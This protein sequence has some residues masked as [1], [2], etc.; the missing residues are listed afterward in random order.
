MNVR[1]AAT[2]LSLLLCGCTALA[3]SR[4]LVDNR[5]ARELQPTTTAG[6]QIQ[7]AVAS[8]EAEAQPGGI[9]LNQLSDRGQAALIEQTK[10]KPPL[11]VKKEAEET[12][13]SVVLKNTITRRL[14]MTIRPSQFLQPGDRVDAIRVQ[15]KIA[16]ARAAASAPQWRIISWTQASAETPID[17]GKLTGV[18]STKITA[19]TGLNLPNLLPGLTIGGE[20]DKSLTQEFQVRD[21]TRLDAAVDQ[22]GV[23]WVDET[24]GWRVDLGHNLAAIDVVALAPSTS[25]VKVVS[26]GPLVKDKDPGKGLPSPA[27]DLRIRT[28]DVYAPNG[29]PNV[30]ICGTALL[31]Y[32]IRHIVNPAAQA[33]FSE[34][35]DDVAYVPGSSTASFIF[36]PPPYQATYVVAV[37]TEDIQY[38]DESGNHALLFLTLEE[39][40]AFK[41]WLAAI[42]PAGGK[43]GRIALGTLRPAF[44]HLSGDDFNHLNVQ[45]SN[46]AALRAGT[47]FDPTACSTGMTSHG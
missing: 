41:N 8:A 4:P 35:D 37:G 40:T 13:A 1:T 15:L 26:V 47:A 3:P 9:P 25:P 22:W 23:A 36:A 20:A 11:I 21:V 10:G 14:I 31:D 33:T 45:P 38:Q 27:K 42:R 32:R 28:V 43:I 12:A 2:S 24:A 46:D 7:I 29:D 39:A 30:P 16:P 19:S 5:F 34:A 44:D 18:S 6:D 17:V